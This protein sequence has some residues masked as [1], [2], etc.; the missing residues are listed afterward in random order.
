MS[1]WHAGMHDNPFGMRLTALMMGAWFLSTSIGNKLAGILSALFNAFETKAYAFG[2][3][4]L[5]ALAAH[6]QG[7]AVAQRRLDVPGV[8]AIAL[9]VGVGA[10]APLR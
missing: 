4:C 8:G 7:L 2:I 1:I 6:A 9:A 10:L 3:N 5:L